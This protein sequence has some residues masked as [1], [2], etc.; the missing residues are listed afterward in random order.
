VL[1]AS[2]STA[3]AQIP[4]SSPG[5]LTLV[6][7]AGFQRRRYK[8]FARI[9]AYAHTYSSCQA[10]S[11]HPLQP[12][13]QACHLRLNTGTN[14]RG[15]R[16]AAADFPSSTRLTAAAAQAQLYAASVSAITLSLPQ[17]GA[18]VAE[19]RECAKSAADAAAAALACVMQ[20]KAELHR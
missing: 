8:V 6:C 17:A 5:C 20:A 10:L 12:R 14:V 2:G 19:T 3:G 9:F 11:S 15:I 7:R 1:S 13:A 4:R 18:R 16:C